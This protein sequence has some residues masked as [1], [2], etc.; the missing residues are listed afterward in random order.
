MDVA[1]RQKRIVEY[2]A[3][4]QS[5]SVSELSRL[6]DVSS[7][8]IRSDLNQ[9]ARAGQVTRTHGGAQMLG[10]RHRQEYTFAKR[11]KIQASQKQEIGELAASLIQPFDTILLDASTTAVSVARALKCVPSLHDVTVLTTGIWTAL[12]VLGCPGLNV[13]LTGGQVRTTTGSITGSITHQVL[14]Q[15]NIQ[16]AF[17]GAWGLT[18]KEGLTDTPLMEVELKRAVVERSQQ[19]IAILDSTKFGR[20]ALASFASIAQVQCVITDPDAPSEM[21]AALKERGVEVLVAHTEY[22]IPDTQG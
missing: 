5:A 18:L 1:E 9:L 7:V 10:E 20:A 8:T 19:V 2:L 11:Q 4:N 13:V 3:E 14:Q 12:E 16:K 22:E 15:V 21:V 6:L 17:L